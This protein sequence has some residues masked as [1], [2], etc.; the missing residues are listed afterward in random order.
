MT[1][2]FFGTIFTLLTFQTFG[3]TRH[4][5]Y[6]NYET[7]ITIELS[8]N[9]FKLSTVESWPNSCI[10]IEH[11][12]GKG[13][14]KISGDTVI[15]VSSIGHEKV[16]LIRETD[17]ILKSL[18]FE[19]APNGQRFY[20]GTVYYEGGKVKE[21]GSWV[22]GKKSGLWMYWNEN[23]EVINKRIYKKGIVKNDNYKFRWEK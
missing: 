19:L 16:T 1:V 12:L 14:T 13:L 4:E 2:K 6:I 11:E 23:G 18:L 15:L 8:G 21:Q 7:G 22:E 5:S 9:T 3:Q 10:A 20:R 17:E